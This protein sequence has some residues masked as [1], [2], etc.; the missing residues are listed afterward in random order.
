MDVSGSRGIPTKSDEASG[1]QVSRRERRSPVGGAAKYD[2]S[3]LLKHPVDVYDI[4]KT[5]PT[6]RVD[7]ANEIC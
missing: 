3:A 1:N 4:L 6:E 2:E 7:S 5:R